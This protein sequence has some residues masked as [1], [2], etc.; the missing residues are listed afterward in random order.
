MTRDELRAA[1][2]ALSSPPPV[3]VES[4]GKAFF[5][6]TLTAYDSDQIRVFAERYR[7]TEDGCSTGRI[8]AQLLCDP[9]GELLF[10]PESL[11]DVLMLSKLE[12]GLRDELMAAARRINSLPDEGEPGNG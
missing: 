7:D 5:V 4:H 8:L 2:A 11:A 10:D 9:A 6:R 1:L 12:P 3:K